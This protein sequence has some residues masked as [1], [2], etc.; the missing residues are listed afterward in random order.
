MCQD[1][2]RVS[3]EVADG[4]GDRVEAVGQAHGERDRL[5]D[6]VQRVVQLR[7]CAAAAPWTSDGVRAE[8]RAEQRARGQLSSV[9][10]SR[11]RPPSAAAQSGPRLAAASSRGCRR[12]RCTQLRT[13]SKSDP[14]VRIL[15]QTDS[16]CSSITTIAEARRSSPHTALLTAAR[17]GRGR[18]GSF[19]RPYGK[20]VRAGLVSS[21]P[22]GCGRCC[23]RCRRP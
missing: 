14:G 6:P 19:R 12:Q 4:A 23:W 8:S 17:R 16:S 22:A 11:P 10:R 9:T 21:P 1:R 18:R 5:A 7:L 3:R 20:R 13:W 15:T 2:T